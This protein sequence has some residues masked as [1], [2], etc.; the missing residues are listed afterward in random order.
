MKKKTFFWQKTVFRG[1]SESE[2]QSETQRTGRHG[3]GRVHRTS[4]WRVLTASSQRRRLVVHDRTDTN[5]QTT[6]VGCSVVVV[7]VVGG[8]AMLVIRRRRRRRR[9]CVHACRRRPLAVGRGTLRRCERDNSKTVEATRVV[10]R[11]MS[12]LKKHARRR[13]PLFAITNITIKIK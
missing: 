9:R 8:G 11:T 6:H 5:K 2:K 1:G 10:R 13:T 12:A 3:D 7:V 4:F